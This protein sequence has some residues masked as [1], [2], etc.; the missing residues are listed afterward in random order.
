[1]PET[2]YDCLS[3]EGENSSPSLGTAV[4]S[5]GSVIGSVAGS[6]TGAVSGVVTGSVAGFDPHCVIVK[7]NTAKMVQTA[8][9]FSVFIS[10]LSKKCAARSHTSKNAWPRCRQRTFARFLVCGKEARGFA[11]S[12]N[13][14]QKIV[15]SCC[16]AL[17]IYHIFFYF[18]RVSEKKGRRRSGRDG[19]T[20]KIPRAVARGLV[21]RTGIEPVLPP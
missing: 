5:S 11:D 21:T 13:A 18:S 14:H 6:V 20:Q 8:A 19:K 7:I 2:T 10:F 17:L 3:L 9:F 1:M 12:K 15:L 4:V 16:L